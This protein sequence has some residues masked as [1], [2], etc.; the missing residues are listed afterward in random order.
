MAD[1]P[2]DPA[3]SKMLITSSKMG[4]SEE[5]LSIVS[6]LSVPSIFIRPKGKEEEADSRKE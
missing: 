1:F 3:L 5:I 4:C 2:L 6:M